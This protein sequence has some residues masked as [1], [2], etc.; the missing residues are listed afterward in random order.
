MK[1]VILVI[2]CL[3]AGFVVGRQTIK[4]KVITKL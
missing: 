4:D 3:F 1:V 2:V